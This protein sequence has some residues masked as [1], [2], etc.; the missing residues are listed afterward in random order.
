MQLTSQRTRLAAIGL[1]LIAAFGTARGQELVVGIGSGGQAAVVAPFA[2]EPSTEAPPRLSVQAASDVGAYADSDHVYVLTPSLSGTV[3]NP[4]AG[5][6]VSG[7]YLLDAVSAASVD[8]VSTASRRWQEVRQAGTLD[9]SYKPGAFGVAAQGVVSSEPD[10]LSWTAGAAVTQ[11]LLDQNVTLLFGFSHG[12][13]VAGRSGTSFSVFS[14]RLDRESVKAGLTLVL[15]ASTVASFVADA[16]VE[17]GDPSKP[18]R[19]IPLFA[20][21]TAVPRGASVEEVTR[22][23]VSARP[24]EQLP[25]SRDRFALSFG[26]SHRFS[27][28][29]LR[30]D[31]RVYADSWTLAASSTDARY[32]LDLGRRME[33]GPHLRVHAQSAVGFWQRAYVLRP[34]FDFPALRTG[35]RELGP[36]V[37]LTSGFTF[38]YGLGPADIPDQW[39]LG[40]D[41]NVTETRYLD[42]LYLTGR[43][44]ALAALSLEARL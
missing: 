28:S 31:E 29:T 40:L 25:L 1:V 39:R 6:R 19:Y 17:H 44:S 23:R 16:I 38:R 11:D 5:Y 33:L 10:Y 2:T 15:D 32:L 37:G 27:A 4:I 41:L 12:H 35:D 34:G 13:D 7:A 14:R 42:D 8:I 36:L 20:P 43:L 21:G 26:L 22:L 24:L 3:T 9:G 18:Y 30:F